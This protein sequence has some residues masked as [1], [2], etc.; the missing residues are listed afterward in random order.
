[1]EELMERLCN[2]VDSVFEAVY[3]PAVLALLAFIASRL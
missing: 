1:M 3:K 2:A